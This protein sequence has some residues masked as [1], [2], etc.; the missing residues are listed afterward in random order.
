MDKTGPI[1]VGIGPLTHRSL[2][3]DLSEKAHAVSSFC[4]LIPQFLRQQWSKL[5][6]VEGEES[7]RRTI[8]NI[9]RMLTDRVQNDRRRPTEW[10]KRTSDRIR[11]NQ[12]MAS[13]L[14]NVCRVFDCFA[15]LDHCKLFWESSLFG[16]NRL[17]KTEHRYRNCPF[18]DST[19]KKF[20][21]RQWWVFIGSLFLQHLWQ[22]NERI[23]TKKNLCWASVRVDSFFVD[24]AVVL[25]T[26]KIARLLAD[27][28]TWASTW[29]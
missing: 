12:K 19:L 24:D 27:H 20:P 16:L 6:F 1:Q 13:T 11:R 18:F 26:M 29:H 4:R 17:F 25:T 21:E 15:F 7:T 9:F 8:T 28:R 10:R 2:D 14:K 22:L 23:G 5:T 3:R